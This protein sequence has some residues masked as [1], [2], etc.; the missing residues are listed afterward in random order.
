MGRAPHHFA[1]LL[2]LS[3]HLNPSIEASICFP[4]LPAGSLLKYQS[5]EE[6]TAISQCRHPCTKLHFS[7]TI[8]SIDFLLCFVF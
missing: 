6:R 3:P 1:P 2:P 5:R 8:S 4:A 7:S